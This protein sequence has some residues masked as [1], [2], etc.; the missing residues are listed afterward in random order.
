MRKT[1]F[2]FGL[3]AA[4]MLTAT[5]LRA[6][7]V[8]TATPSPLQES[9]KDVV[10]TFHA[11][12]GNR[13]LAG[14]ASGT[15]VYA[16]IGVITTLSKSNS[17]WKY[18]PA[19]W[20]LNEDH[21]KLTRVGNSDEWTLSIGDIRTYFNIKNANEHVKKIAVV[22]RSA[23]CQMQGKDV[24][25][26]DIFVDVLPEGLQISLSS[27]LNSPVIIKP[28]KVNFTA[29]STEAG[30]ITIDVNGTKI[31][32]KSG[33][34]E[35]TASYD[36][37]TVGSYTVTATVNAGG[38]T[39]KATTEVQYIEASEAKTFP[40]GTP[41]MGYT[42]NTDGTV[43][44][45]V[46]APGK[47]SVT[48]VPSWNDYKVTGA[49]RMYYQDYE[50]NRYFW[51]TVNGLK[52]GESYLYYY[53]IDGVKG[54]AD[55][56]SQLV[57]DPYNDKWLDPAVFPDCP[58]Y[59]DA[60]NGTDIP[61]TVYTPGGWEYDWEVP[62]FNIPDPQQLVIYEIL[63]R[64]FTGKE[65]AADGNGTVAAAIEHIPYLKEL[66]VNAVELMPIME[67]NGNLSW[68]YN[69]N[70]YFAPDKAYGAPVDYKKF[71]DECHK[72][73]MAVILDI[74]LNQSD[75]LHPWYQMYGGTSNNP[76][77]NATAPHDYSVLNDWNQDNPL[78]EQQWVDALKF[79]MEEY[80]VDGFRFDLVK[81]LGD[82]DS[83]RSSGTEGYNKSRVERM[84][85]L[86]AAI[87]AVNP[88]GIHINENL[89]GSKEENEMGADGQLNWS[90]LNWQTGQ[91]VKMVADQSSL[92]GFDAKVWGR[93]PGTTV[94]YMESHDEQR[95]A[96][97]AKESD[98]AAISKNTTNAYRRIGSAAAQMLLTP[99]AKMI[100]QFGEL[101]DD[102][103]TKNSG[104]NDTGNKKVM[105]DTYLNDSRRMGLHDTF[106]DLINIRR[107][108]PS[109]FDGTADFSTEGMADD[110]TKPRILTLRQGD[111]EVVALINP[112]TAS[113]DITAKT[114]VISASNAKVLAKSFHSSFV[115]EVTDSGDG[116]KVTVPGNCFVALGS[117]AVTT[118]IDSIVTGEEPDRTYTV[119]GGQGCVI[120][121]GEYDR[122]E[123]YD[124]TGR[125]YGLTGLQAGIYIVNVDGNAMKVAVK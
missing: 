95:V 120:V 111:Q 58:S 79:W 99:G 3:L 56:Y 32:E 5:S 109:L 27:D 57:L 92:G 103:N 37:Q 7:D 35:L 28:T 89:A 82:N 113:M 88:R 115:P 39:T 94:A 44:F 55:P 70:F 125:R 118:G 23:D 47:T 8:V 65:G 110:L 100:W 91:Y 11:D 42:E 2:F 107:A 84:K 71:V 38:E 9:S 101:A 108:N 4:I 66:G 76:F 83:Y 122:A 19:E 31:A 22:F 48:I 20:T 21:R 15:Q 10:L 98:N 61:L 119:K 34:K 13:G 29:S 106:R 51:I 1:L 63:F 36:F 93:T 69:T 14:V 105:W 26:T 64:D 116:I 75:W 67:F 123:V 40:G 41:R 17:D 81:G 62:D 72:A 53:L 45:C 87:K 33:A 46:A 86:H 54:V 73:G 85:R 77:Y 24:G 12:R 43:T 90:N 74:V 112:T 18:A 96:F 59:P 117:K 80:N 49:N 121:D 6:A 78:V 50:D 124:M 52:K 97:M 114:G 68:G 60:L 30:E 25:D 16:H 104:G 102:Q